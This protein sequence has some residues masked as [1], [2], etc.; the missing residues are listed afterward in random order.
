MAGMI[1]IRLC[2]PEDLEAL[3]AIAS[4]TFTDTFA[5]LN[6]PVHFAPYIAKAFSLGQ[7]KSELENP[8]TEFYFLFY[9]DKLAGYLKLNFAEAQS[10]LNDP[11]SLEIERIYV[12]DSFQGL[13]L[14]KALFQ[15]SLDKALD[16]SLKYVWLGVWEKN[17]KAIDFYK[18]RGFYTFDKHPFKLGD[19]LQTDYLMRLDL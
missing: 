14:G 6:D 10:D 9:D 15:L 11:E 13:G 3:T 12:L 18:T 5:H 8:A 19:D 16:Q 17:T 4:Q 7:I 2:G 1:E